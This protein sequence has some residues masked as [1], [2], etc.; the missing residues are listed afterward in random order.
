METLALEDIDREFKLIPQDYRHYN[1]FIPCNYEAKA[2]W[3]DYIERCKIA[4]DFERKRKIKAIK[5]LLLQYVTRFPKNK[6]LYEPK[7]PDK[8]LHYEDRWKVYYSLE[9]GFKLDKNSSDFI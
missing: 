5:P 4:D 1:V 9:T 6:N 2:V 7:N 8:F 3:K